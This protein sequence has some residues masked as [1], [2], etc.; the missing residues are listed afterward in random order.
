[1]TRA[2]P[3][4]SE[5]IAFAEFPLTNG[6]GKP[7]S[8]DAASVKEY[9]LDEVVP[10]VELLERAVAAARAEL[11][12]AQ[13][14][15]RTVEGDAEE[16]LRARRASQAAAGRRLVEQQLADAERLGQKWIDDS[17]EWARGHRADAEDYDA[18]MRASWSN[19]QDDNL[20]PRPAPSGD[21]SA[22]ALAEAEWLTA[23]AGWL[24]ENSGELRSRISETVASLQAAAAA[25]PGDPPTTT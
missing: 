18:A 5:S 14:R 2:T 22:D 24:R 4:T 23:M 9:L 7:R 15:V 19:V 3:L 11:E 21:T 16:E 20:P 8:Y 1:M 13:Q 10:T 25:L 17:V 6:R 12:A